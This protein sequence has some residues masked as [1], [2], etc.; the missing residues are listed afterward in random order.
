MKAQKELSLSFARLRGPYCRQWGVL[1]RS[2]R[3]RKYN[4][5]Y[6][7]IKSRGWG[8]QGDWIELT[9]VKGKSQWIWS[10]DEAIGDQ[11]QKERHYPNTLKARMLQRIQGEKRQERLRQMS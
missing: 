2:R 4:N 7:K 3:K 6:W 8:R 11:C 5:S 10:K 1:D 9:Q